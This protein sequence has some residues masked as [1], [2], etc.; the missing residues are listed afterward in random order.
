[1]V[2]EHQK[3]WEE[4]SKWCCNGIL[5]E[6]KLQSE[7][8]SSNPDGSNSNLFKKKQG[9]DLVGGIEGL[10]SNIESSVPEN[11]VNEVVIE[12]KNEVITAKELLRLSLEKLNS[13]FDPKD[14]PI[15]EYAESICNNQKIAREIRETLQILLM[16]EK[17]EIEMIKEKS[18]NP[19]VD[20]D[21]TMSDDN[22]DLKFYGILFILIQI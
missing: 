16:K 15:E 3:K 10:F 8:N 7:A 19:K 5:E 6:L 12:S 1:M 18:Y 22:A 14:L 20:N 13:E 2:K 4:I 21:A 17:N 9:V 11:I